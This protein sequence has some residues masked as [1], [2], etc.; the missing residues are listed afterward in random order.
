MLARAGAVIFVQE[1]S[2]NEGKSFRSQIHKSQYYFQNHI[3]SFHHE[4]SMKPIQAP[5]FYYWK[6]TAYRL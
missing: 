5:V 1:N 4:E 3:S 6:P 2:R